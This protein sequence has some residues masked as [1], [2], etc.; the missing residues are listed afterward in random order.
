MRF[1]E[2]IKSY[3]FIK[4]EDKLCVYKKI[5]GSAITFLVLY[6]DDILLIRNDVSMLS[7]VKADNMQNIHENI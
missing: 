7:L 3:D 6:V 5:S 4:N 2:A 1:D